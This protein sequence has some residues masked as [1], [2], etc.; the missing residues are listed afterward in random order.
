MAPRLFP[1][2]GNLQS[3][4]VPYG[5]EGRQYS[6]SIRNPSFEEFDEWTSSGSRF[7]AE[8]GGSPHRGRQHS[9]ACKERPRLAL[10]DKNTNSEQPGKSRHNAQENLTDLFSCWSFT[11]LVCEV[12]HG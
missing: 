12:Y 6:S 9:A 7:A 10:E 1:C 5:E 11:R 3:L 2:R 8:F 4:R